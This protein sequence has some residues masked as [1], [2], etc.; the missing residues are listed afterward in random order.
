M[1]STRDTEEQLFDLKGSIMKVYKGHKNVTSNTSKQKKDALKLLR[2]N[3]DIIVKPSDKCKGF[4]IMD[5]K[6]YVDRAKAILT[7]PENY[8]S[9]EKDLTHEV[10]ARVKRVF[11]QNTKGKLPDKLV[12]DLTPRHSRTPIF[13]G[14]PKDHKPSV[15]LRPVVSN[16][17]GPTE[18]T[19]VMLEKIL[20]QLIQFV[21]LHLV[22]TKDF[23]D[24]LKGFWEAHDVPENAILFSI[25]VKNLYGSIPLDGAMEAVRETLEHHFNDIDTCG[26][27]VD[28]ICDLLEQCLMN[29]V[30]RFGDEYFLQKQGVAM[31]NPVAPIVAIL[32]MNRFETL[33]LQH[34]SLK[35]AFLVRYI[36]DFA[37]VWLGGKE[38][39]VEFLNYLNSINGRIQFTCE[40]TEEG[41]G[42]IPMLDVLLTVTKQDSRCKLTTELFIKP[43][44][45]GIILHYKSAHPKE[46]KVN[47]VR[48][49]FQRAIRLSSDEQARE[50]SLGK[51]DDLL[52]KNGYP[53][54]L[55]ARIKR[56][57]L[58][59]GRQHPFRR[60][61]GQVRRGRRS[62]P[63][64]EDRIY[65]TLPYVDETILCKVKKVVKKSKFNVNLGWYAPN[66][67]KDA[68][69]LRVN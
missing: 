60:D 46:T 47:M 59:T 51:I 18:K 44:N 31:G 2:D 69:L 19:S 66:T 65:L 49:Q 7:D 68:R 40:M 8:E 24:K 17:G 39:L 6:D 21:P 9:V 43:N 12:E 58:M 67:L 22:D 57:T 16:C 20:H 14:L 30:F 15:P 25:D 38:S 26:L 64:T 54:Q 13:Y 11:K 48:S 10:E 36:D 5:K 27:S 1:P 32:F 28:E 53:M 35:P 4:V 61:G 45:A 42:S 55:V 41:T 62:R 37:G 56:E 34:A 3:E 23:L 29:N 52:K 33:A 50:R 63:G